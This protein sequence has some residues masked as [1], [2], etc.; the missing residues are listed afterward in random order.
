MACAGPTPG[1]PPAQRRPPVA[2]LLA[3]AVGTLDASCAASY[4]RDGFRVAQ[5]GQQ[6]DRR[7]RRRCQH[8]QPRRDDH[9]SREPLHRSRRCR[10]GRNGGV[11]TVERQ[12]DSADATPPPTLAV[13]AAGQLDHRAGARPPLC[14]AGVPAGR[15]RPARPAGLPAAGA[16][17]TQ[18]VDGVP[19]GQSLPWCLVAPIPVRARR[20]AAA[21]G[22]PAGDCLDAAGAVRRRPSPASGRT[23]LRAGVRLGRGVE[24][25]ERRV[26]AGLDRW[27][28]HRARDPSSPGRSR[29]AP[30]SSAAASSRGCRPS[31]GPGRGSS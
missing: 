1:R 18:G 26:V 19:R 13:P 10:C 8:R 20:R 28:R 9:H 12:R 15:V 6:R 5:H 30:G 23:R 29:P 2:T 27:R 4:S 22:V 25:V 11:G 7:V 17:P 16:R 21:R 31:A 14:G 24:D 3:A